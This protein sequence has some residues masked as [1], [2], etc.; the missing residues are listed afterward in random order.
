MRSHKSKNNRLVFIGIVLFFISLLLNDLYVY[1]GEKISVLPEQ[2][3]ESTTEFSMASSDVVS[4]PSYGQKIGSLFVEGDL[5][6]ETAING[7]TAYAVSG[8]ATIGFSYDGGYNSDKKDVWNLYDCREKKIG[9]IKLSKKV[10]NG[11]IVVKKSNDGKDFG[12]D[13]VQVN[14]L[15]SNKKVDLNAL[16]SVSEEEIKDGTYYR[17]YVIYSLKRRPTGAKKD[18]YKYCID[19]YDFYI[20][21]ADDPISILD[22]SSR[23]IVND[24]S[25]VKEGFTLLNN[26]SNA[27][28]TVKRGNAEPKKVNSYESF[29][30]P[31]TYT[32]TAISPIGDTFQKTVRVSEGSATISASPKKYVN[33]ERTGYKKDSSDGALVSGRTLSSLIIAQKAGKKINM[34]LTK[35]CPSYGIS[36]KRADIYLRVT[37]PQTYKTSGWEV[38]SDTWGKKEDQKIN[39]ISTKTAIGTGALIVQNSADGVTWS[40]QVA[41]NT[42]YTTDYY[43]NYSQK[44]DILIYQPKGEAIINGVYIKV[45]YAYEIQEVGGKDKRR[46]IEEYI[47]YL[48]NDELGAITFHNLTIKGQDEDSRDNE[49]KIT[50]N[51]YKKAE[52]IESGAVTATGFTIDTSEN[53]TASIRVK[54]DGEELSFREGMTLTETGRYDI[55][56]K[57]V[58]G[59]SKDVTIYVDRMTKEETLKVYFDGSFIEGKRIYDENSE[60]PVFE[61][62]R[63]KYKFLSVSD[64]YLPLYGEIK[65]ISTGESEKIEAS[66]SMRTKQL[67]TPGEYEIVLN[68]NPTC[69]TKTP[70][71]DNKVI[72]FRFKIIPEGTAPGP[73][74]NKRNL[75]E[76]MNNSVAGVFP[77]YY[78]LQYI[79][80]KGGHICLAFKTYEAAKEYAYDHEKGTVENNPDG[81]Y[82]YGTD[83]NKPKDR[84]D[85]EWALTQA[86]NESAEKAVQELYFDAS[87]ETT[88]RTVR[89]ETL[90]NIGGLDKLDTYNSVVV[91]ADGQK[92]LL[93]NLDALPIINSLPYSY[94]EPKEG[95][96]PE[97][98]KQSFEFIKDKYGC[99]SNIV[100]IT[101]KEGKRAII[102]Y[103]KDVE[104]QLKEKGFETGIVTITEETI[105]G[106]STSYEAVYYAEGDNTASVTVLLKGEN[107]ETLVL[108]KEDS[109]KTIDAEAFSIIDIK[110]SL[111]PYSSVVVKDTK[112]KRTMFL[113]M[114]KAA[115]KIWTNAGEYEVYVVNRLGNKYSFTINISDGKYASISYKGEGT[116]TFEP[117]LAK[118]GEENVKLQI[119]TR[120]GYEFA[121]YDDEDGNVFDEVIDKISFSG[122]K[123]LSPRWRPK[124]VNIILKDDEGNILDMLETSYGSEVDLPVPELSEGKDFQGWKA[125]DDLIK[126]NKLIVTEENDITI[127]ASCTVSAKKDTVQEANE[128]GE[129]EKS[130][131]GTSKKNSPIIPVLII[132]ALGGGV[133]ACVKKKTK[134]RK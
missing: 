43:K 119:P 85:S 68:N 129:S 123:T 1:A 99:D 80:N 62:G 118:K 66:K 16:L 19:K 26:G 3:Y 27:S 127:E 79:R 41:K 75:I 67:M 44:G 98:G 12:N 18:I 6:N 124:K 40:D 122:E 5:K 108:S 133:A 117:V 25:T 93:T 92:E 74:V 8:K 90:D 86:L 57:S 11:S 33:K 84:Y 104:G 102:D 45:T 111:D 36:G 35:G 97:V 78:G 132:A 51:M 96:M 53:P 24:N 71:G 61:G 46:C 120:Y 105:Y 50:V 107:K 49:D 77:K 126:D 73:Q 38:V 10:G 21:Y 7:T 101:D 9:D 13:Y 47:F 23:K 113:G 30:A 131:D 17:V 37:D 54:K 95:K 65:N 125:N 70:S 29:Y 59:S 130:N 121:G 114:E 69:K 88:F 134:T 106:D 52:T 58:A 82:S 28:I 42:V 48:C 39:G 22:V 112:S 109:G 60:Y 83:P 56:L 20:C 15:F 87:D 115:E 34:A 72:T 55:S 4:Q 94:Q 116:E 32:I 64:E 100:V 110:D 89:K 63:T 128:E 91:F 2:R 31:G 103:E 76:A 81:T 14:N